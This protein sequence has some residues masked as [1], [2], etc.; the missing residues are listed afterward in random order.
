[1]RKTVVFSN[2]NGILREQRSKARAA[3]V[4]LQARDVRSYMGN[5]SPDFQF[6]NA[7]AVLKLTSDAPENVAKAAGEIR[8]KY[9]DLGVVFFDDVSAL[10]KGAEE[11]PKAEVVA[12]VD[13]PGPGTVEDM[14]FTQNKRRSR[15]E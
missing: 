1:M 14:G 6:R 5:W 11:A 9:G 12:G 8:A 13:T 3:G 15:K 7:L 4:N 2:D 10:L